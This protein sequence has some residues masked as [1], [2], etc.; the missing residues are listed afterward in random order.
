MQTALQATASPFPGLYR[1]YGTRPTRFLEIA[2]I[3]AEVTLKSTGVVIEVAA[4]ELTLDGPQLR[5]TFSGRRR[6]QFTNASHDGH[7]QR[8]VQAQSLGT[9][10]HRP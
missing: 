3:I 1:Q 5:V 7:R 10:D 8:D 9:V 6:K 2:W 4:L